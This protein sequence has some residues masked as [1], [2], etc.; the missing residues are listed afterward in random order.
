[1]EADFSGYAT[2]AG[3]KCADGR[4]IMPEAFKHQDQ[5]QVPLVWMH[6][7]SDPTNVLGHAIL[8]AREDGIYTRCFFN[9]TPK[10][11]H[12]K[13]A[14]G[15]KD[16][17]HMSIWAN[18]LVE[19]AKRVFHGSIREVSL[20]LNGANPGALIENVSIRHGDGL[21]TELD[22]EAI[23]YTGIEFELMH[24]SGEID[25]DDDDDDYIDDDPDNIDPSDPDNEL[26]HAD[27]ADSAASEKTI[28]DV[29]D[30]M[31]DEQQDV[32]H[33]MVGEALSNAGNNDNADSLQQSYMEGYEM[34]RSNVFENAGNDK[35]TPVLSHDDM[36]GIVE[37]AASRGSL[38][39]AVESYALQHG[40]EN[41]DILFPDAVAL[42]NT[43]EWFGRRTDW[44]DKVIGGCR[45]SP[46][47]NIKTMSADINE[48]D[49]RA[50]GYI[51]G[52]LKRDEFFSVAKRQTTPTTIYKKQKLERDDVIDI[53]GFD[54]VAWLKGEMRLMLDEEIAR[55]ILI[56]DGRD[57]SSDDKI[58]EQNIRPVAKDHELYTTLVNVNIDDASSTVQEIVDALVMNRKHLRG[59]GL[60]TM[61]TTE[62][63]IAKFL[64]LKDT[65]GRRI[66][67]SLDELAS[68]LRVS[69][70]VA[71]EVM[72][73]EPDMIAVLVNL[74]DYV[75]GANKGGEVSMFEDF[76][77]DYNAQK[78]LIETRVSGALTKLK[79]AMVVMKTASTNVLVAP[80]APTFNAETGVLTIVNQA[81]VVYKNGNT[82]VNAAGSPYAA[83]APGASITI[84]ATAASGYYFATSEDDSWTF[85]REV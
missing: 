30:S 39:K 14:V 7:H 44:V 35:D 26:G 63:Y 12:A 13:I 78:Y 61:Y 22:D 85:T 23:I 82:V 80:N 59:T 84:T 46:F 54:V 21:E 29:Y 38:K 17:K 18:E 71:V 36:K 3:L 25:D 58:N 20:V 49:A 19:R 64:L 55:A 32:L 52:N 79:S 74:V 1:M 51:K 28:A 67:K 8:E 72:E 24:S 16:I 73:E 62:T 56:G 48:D 83:I 10:A 11:Q 70:I 6:G 81:G 9:D 15:H 4:T 65:L 42:D 43:P 53:T 69:E 41:I 47:A 5:I 27:M 60:P 75:I 31:S 40:I 37:D 76:D 33:Y 77:I 66:Y 34:G 57:I 50:K 45:K 2:K 68:E